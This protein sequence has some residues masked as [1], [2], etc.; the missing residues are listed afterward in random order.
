MRPHEAVTAPEW[1]FDL[2]SRRA[3][4]GPDMLQRSGHSLCCV[5]VCVACQGGGAPASAMQSDSAGGTS[6]GVAQVLVSVCSGSL[7]D[8]NPLVALA[9]A[10]AGRGAA[11]VAGGYRVVVLANPAHEHRVRAADARLG[12]RAVGSAE[13]YAANLS[14]PKRFAEPARAVRRWL[15]VLPEHY[16]ALLELVSAAPEG[17]TVVV[18]HTLDLAVRCLEEAHPHVR[19][20]TVVLQ[21]WLIRSVHAPPRLSRRL[22]GRASA[23]W[24]ELARGLLFRLADAAIDRLYA[25]QLDAFRASIGLAPVRRV[26]HRWFLCERRVLLLFPSWYAAPQPDWP[27]QAR[28]LSSFASA[29]GAGS[30]SAPLPPNVVAFMHGARE[31]GQPVVAFTPGSANPPHAAAF[32]RAS[33]KAC[34]RRGFAGILLTSH[35]DQLPSPLPAHVMSAAYLPFGTLLPLVDAVVYNGGIGTAANAMSAGVAHLIVP[36]CVDQFDNA[37]RVQALG[38]GATLHVKQYTAKAAGKALAKLLGS[39]EVRARCRELKQLFADANDA[40]QEACKVVEDMLSGFA[41]SSSMY[42]LRGAQ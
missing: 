37:E 19:C 4:G 36:Q 41:S 22:G 21:P 18:G 31:I 10:L 40:W 39:A 12:F 7:G 3:E 16:D 6:R 9:A 38:V 11:D 29:D 34:E 26:Y 1:R 14:D 28:Q 33:A 15:S 20:C 13:A 2:A 30:S 32:L 17:S 8:V 5:S 27:K 24:P 25:P 42:D 23:W 35:V